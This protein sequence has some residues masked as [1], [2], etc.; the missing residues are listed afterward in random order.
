MS[1]LLTKAIEDTWNECIAKL[2]A[3]QLS[4]EDLLWNDEDSDDDDDDE[5]E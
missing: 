2:N 4:P 3:G 1:L 5:A